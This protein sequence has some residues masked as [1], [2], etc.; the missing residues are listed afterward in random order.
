MV[1]VKNEKE[2]LAAIAQGFKL[3][4]HLVVEKGIV[5]R[6]IECSVMG[7]G[8][9]FVSTPG[10]ICT[11]GAIYDYESKYGEKAFDV[12]V[13][14]DLTAEQQLEAKKM[15]LAAFRAI[16]CDG[17]A[18]VD[19]FLQPDGQFLLN[20]INPIP[21]CTKNSLFPKMAENSGLS[22]SSLLVQATELAIGRKVK[23]DRIL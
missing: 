1:K 19:L 13:E 16:G 11:K 18:R 4:T 10:E 15:A 5:G 7:R 17:I 20:E 21:G 2:L 3:D 23:Q 8:P 14:A 22:F 9:W 12:K 6:E